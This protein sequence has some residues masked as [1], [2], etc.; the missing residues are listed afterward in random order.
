MEAL[1]MFTYN[2]AFASFEEEIKGSLEEGKAADIVVLSDDFL[3]CADDKI[4]DMKVEMTMI[5]G[6]IVFEKGE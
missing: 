2:G 6:K 4:M 3:E 5:D 1:R